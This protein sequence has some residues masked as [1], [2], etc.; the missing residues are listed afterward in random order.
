M[1]NGKG[2]Y[3]SLYTAIVLEGNAKIVRVQFLFPHEEGIAG[4]CN[5]A[6]VRCSAATA[7][8]LRR[9]KSAS[10]DQVACLTLS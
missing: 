1:T 3:R 5:I 2:K 9:K 6:L 8:Y 4:R 7:L 10:S